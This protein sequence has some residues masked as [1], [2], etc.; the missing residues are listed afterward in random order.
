MNE[1]K[2]TL[3]K[4]LH[5]P[6][7][8][9]YPRRSVK[10]RGLDETWQADLVD[11][12]AYAEQN[13]GH[14]LML[15]LTDIFSKY[16][17]AVPM[18][19]KTGEE[20]ASAMKFVLKRGRVPKHLQVDRG[21]EFYNSHFE[22]L[23]RRYKIKL[24]STFSN[25]KAS[26]C[27]RF[28]R[29]IK[30]RMWI[31]FSLQ[32]NYEWITIL[33]DFISTYNNTKHR[34]IQM[35]PKDVSITNEKMLLRSMYGRARVKPAL[36]PKFKAGDKVR[37]S[38]LK[39]VSDKGSTPNWTTKIFTIDQVANTDPVTYK[40]KDYRNQ[41]VAG[42]FH[43]L[44]LLRAANFDTY[45]I[46]KV[47]RKRGKKLFVKWLGFDN[48]HNSWINE[49]NLLGCFK[50][51]MIT[52][53]MND[54]NDNAYVL[55]KGVYVPHVWA[56]QLSPATITNVIERAMALANMPENEN[57][58]I[59]FIAA[60]TLFERYKTLRSHRPKSHKKQHKT[61]LHDT[62]QLQ[63]QTK[64]PYVL[65]VRGIERFSLDSDSDENFDDQDDLEL[66]EGCY[67]D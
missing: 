8:R 63:S 23:M 52:S 3:V 15:T 41:P 10:V 31:E 18:K 60:Q 13:K 47:L 55:F 39:N 4:E 27:E 26:I 61:Q 64:K 30:N 17:W 57:S 58:H 46:E 53:V 22:D 36:A 54:M 50:L 19:N 34:T 33:P 45:L 2:L 48:T 56:A 42:G 25:L 5:K 11:M 20:T 28:I 66:D 9:N 51:N 24:Y 14:H 6:A 37:V 44:E 29:T 21:K 38:K 67:A 62:T 16:A 12:S 32:G 40:L 49:N 35:K 59:Y 1:K 65:I 7:R 43:E